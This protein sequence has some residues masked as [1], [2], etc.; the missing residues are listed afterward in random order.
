MLISHPSEFVVG[1]FSGEPGLAP[2][3]WR[4]G[5]KRGAAR[6]L[7]HRRALM[8]VVWHCWVAHNGCAAAAQQEPRGKRKKVSSSL[9]WPQACYQSYFLF[10]NH[11]NMVQY[12]LKLKSWT[13]VVCTMF[14]VR[15]MCFKLVEYLSFICV[16]MYLSVSKCLSCIFDNFKWNLTSNGW[17]NKQ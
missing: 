8:I 2:A 17:Y 9:F 16:Q 10:V 13:Q 14:C 5:W 6:V 15:K 3:A 12:F 7:D 4:P 11:I 1:A